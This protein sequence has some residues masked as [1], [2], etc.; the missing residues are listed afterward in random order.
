[1][2]LPLLFLQQ[3]L[4]QLLQLQLQLILL[5]IVQHLLLIA[6][7]DLGRHYR[8]SVV[9]EAVLEGRGCRRHVLHRQRWDRIEI[10]EG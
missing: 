5:L 1:M 6:N 4:I 9:I 10:G 3:I 7:V 2:L 8:A